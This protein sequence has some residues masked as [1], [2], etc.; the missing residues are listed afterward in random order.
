VDFTAA[1][2]RRKPIVAALARI[3][4]ARLMIERVERV[5]GFAAFERLLAMPGPWHGGFDFPFGQPR[6]LVAACGWP[7]RWTACVDRVARMTRPA[8]EARIYEFMRPRPAGTKLLHR[9]TDRPA[10]SSSPMQLAYVPVGK[11]FFEGALRLRRA[12][13]TVP[14]MQRGDPTRVAVEA[15]PGL[16]ARKVVGRT[17]YKND[18]AGVSRAPARQ[19][20]VEALR[21]GALAEA[22]GFRVELRHADAAALAAARDADAIDAVLAALQ[23]AWSASR[24]DYGLPR[25][26]DTLEGWIADPETAQ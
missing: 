15:Y 26:F 19:R 8:F 22:Y 2:S 24:S 3:R 14:R 1:P 18:P 25:A 13:V 16:A 11:M 20:L 17:S 21:D 10:G 23:A 4:G 5:E 12:R 6:E 9:A 7:L